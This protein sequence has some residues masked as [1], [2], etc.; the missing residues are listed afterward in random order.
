[1]HELIRDHARSMSSEHHREF[2]LGFQHIFSKLKWNDIKNEMSTIAMHISYEIM[3]TF[4]D[5]VD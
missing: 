3:H 1:M 4:V 2:C 5:N